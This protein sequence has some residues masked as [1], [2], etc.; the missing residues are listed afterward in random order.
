MYL[1]GCVCNCVNAGNYFRPMSLG[2]LTFLL[3]YLNTLFQLAYRKTF[4]PS[5]SLTLTFVI[6]LAGW[7]DGCSSSLIL[8]KLNI[9][10]PL[11]EFDVKRINNASV[12]LLYIINSRTHAY[13]VS[14]RGGNEERKTETYVDQQNHTL[15]SPLTFLYW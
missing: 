7:L 11:C 2:Q 14:K 6:G 3:N 13:I 12:P 8:S 5:S 9:P 10:F 15:S 1:C 4:D